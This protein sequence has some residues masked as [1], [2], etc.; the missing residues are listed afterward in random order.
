MSAPKDR[1]ILEAVLE[2]GEAIL[3]AIVNGDAIA[4]VPVMGIAFKIAR[5][6][7]S[8]RDRALAAKLTKF[9]VQ[10][11]KISESSRQRWKVKLTES[12]DEATRVGEMLF[13][14]IDRAT[15]LKK[16]DV[17]AF[18]FIAY[19]DGVLSSD[20][21][22]RMSQAVDTAFIDDLEQLLNAHDVPKESDAP[23]MKYL[24]SSGLTFPS[25]KGTLG[26]DGVLIYD[27]SSLG[28]K[29]RTAYFH[30]RKQAREAA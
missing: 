22:R 3:D 2:S 26:D 24:A 30:G 1:P 8:I 18:L 9:M 4:S 13:L 10:F 7:D 11:E 25:G 19:I 21:L 17:L 28:H 20:E 29:C 27:V 23:W 6:A 15:D 14:V 12:P 5:A 16:A